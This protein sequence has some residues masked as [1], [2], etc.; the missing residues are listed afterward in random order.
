MK[1]L[2][3]LILFLLGVAVRAEAQKRPLDAMNTIVIKTNDKPPV[4]I[5]KMRQ[6]M[7]ADTLPIAHLNLK[8]GTIR[9]E[10]LVLPDVPTR[11]RIEAEANKGEVVIRAWWML[12]NLTGP[13]VDATDGDPIWFEKA[14]ALAKRYPGALDIKYEKRGPRP[15]P[16]KFR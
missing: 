11:C 10:P 6:L 4:A 2:S 3:L 15:Q 14:R 12:T 1:H 5:E 13:V 7:M 9:T 8:K 16:R